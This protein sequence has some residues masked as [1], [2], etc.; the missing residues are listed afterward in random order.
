MFKAVTYLLLVASVDAV[1][2]KNQVGADFKYVEETNP[3]YVSDMTTNTWNLYSKSESL[4]LFQKSEYMKNKY[5]A[6]KTKYAQDLKVAKDNYD[7][8]LDKLKEAKN[9]LKKLDVSVNDS[10]NAK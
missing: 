7:D 6:Q 10:I 2:I 1:E 5:A 9:S 3:D 4:D 8:A